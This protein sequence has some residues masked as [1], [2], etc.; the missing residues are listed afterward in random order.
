MST[1]FGFKGPGSSALKVL[2]LTS[3]SWVV[4]GMYMTASEGVSNLSFLP[5][6][7]PYW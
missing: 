2:Q 5:S 4:D 3:S 7:L 1:G 6:C